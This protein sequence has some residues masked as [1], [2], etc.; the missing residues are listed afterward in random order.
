MYHLQFAR[1]VVFRLYEL[2]KN[3]DKENIIDKCVRI[4]IDSYF[5][6]T[7]RIVDILGRF[8][9]PKEKT[10]K[11]SLRKNCNSNLNLKIVILEIAALGTSFMQCLLSVSIEK[12]YLICV[13]VRAET[14]LKLKIF[15]TT[16]FGRNCHLL[17]KYLSIFLKKCSISPFRQK[18]SQEW[19]KINEFILG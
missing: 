11:K 2:V 9:T 14:P 8:R 6:E 15:C 13:F 10:L 19:Q 16:N 4:W 5:S 12:N 18:F 17:R 7:F 1:K 3:L